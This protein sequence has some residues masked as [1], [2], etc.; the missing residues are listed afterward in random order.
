MDIA[1]ILAVIGLLYIAGVKKAQHLN[2]KELCETS[3]SA[4]EC[5]RAMISKERFL[6]VFQALWLMILILT[7]RE[8]KLTIYA[9]F[10]GCR[11]VYKQV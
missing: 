11:G 6:L 8:R 3:C 4:P 10:L 7:M 9:L 5:F 1:E 2:M